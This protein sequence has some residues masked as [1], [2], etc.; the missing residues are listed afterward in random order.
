MKNFPFSSRWFCIFFVKIQVSVW[1][2]SV[3]SWSFF[4]IKCDF[5]GGVLLFNPHTWGQSSLEAWASFLGCF[6]MVIWLTDQCVSSGCC[7]RTAFPAYVKKNKT[8]NNQ[9][10]CCSVAPSA[11]SGPL[12][13]RLGGE[14]GE[15]RLR[16]FPQ[17]PPWGVQ[18]PW[19]RG[20]GSPHMMGP[21]YSRRCLTVNVWRFCEREEG[22]EAEGCRVKVFSRCVTM[23]TLWWLNGG[24]TLS[25]HLSFLAS[26]SSFIPLL[27][28]SSA[29]C[30]TSSFDFI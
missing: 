8:T 25:S 22:G 11:A 17:G 27:L 21:G 5:W 19:Q 1:S 28:L 15:V 13:W 10:C 18:F 7:V 9:I 3:S 16:V 30:V 23:V 12:T 14:R 2:F 26:T 4:T 29:C 6:S 24:G 20:S